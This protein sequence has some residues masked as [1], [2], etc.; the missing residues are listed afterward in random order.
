[1]KN[2]K[3]LLDTCRD[4]CTGC[5]LCGS[6][7]NKPFHSDEKGFLY[8]ALEEADRDFCSD[9]CPAAG[10]AVNSYSDG[11]IFGKIISCRLG[12]ANDESLRFKASSGGVLSA[13][14]IYLLEHNIVD[15]IIQTK[16]DDSD[17]RKTVTVVS[18][19]AQDVRD[20]AGSRYTASSPLMNIESLIEEGKKYAFVGKPCDVSALRMLSHSGRVEWTKQIV[21]MFS[22]FCAGQ[23]SIAANNKLLN[24]LGCQSADECLE[25]DYRG[26][27]WP[28]YA[29]VVTKD[30]KSSK[31]DYERSWMTILG[32]DVRRCC[33]FCA[34]G[35]GEQADI[36]CGDAWYL[37]ADGKPDFTD[38]PGRNVVFS[39]TEA[40]DRLL[41]DLTAAGCI[42]VE[43]YDIEKDGLKKSQ[44]YH[45]NRKA[46]L[47]SLKLAM[48]VCR[49]NF[50][51]YDSKK[52]KGY[53]KGYPIKSK[54]LRCIGTIKRV[55]SKVI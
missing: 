45:Y 50:P 27:G 38:R 29:A 40:G 41:H 24:A 33:R 7:L 21:Y 31:M 48:S 43:P 37:G 34:D 16:K 6:V 23:P 51:L 1:M 25:F 53:A 54:T 22:F 35:T 12:W 20:C 28:G 15:G 47:S 14:C 26:N 32:R 52:M 5:G 55:W 30:G 8:P 13:V 4:Y 44:P 49:K 39:R 9:V 2:N 10:K 46:S 42:T 19:T 36:S 11:T 3:N 18:K 17:L